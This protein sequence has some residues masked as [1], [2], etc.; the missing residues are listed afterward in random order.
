[1]VQT[2]RKKTAPMPRRAWGRTGPLTLSLDVREFLGVLQKI[3]NG[4]LFRNVGRGW[5]RFAGVTKNIVGDGACTG[6]VVADT[7]VQWE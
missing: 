6:V 7:T 1:M 4:F 5:H 3:A 2:K